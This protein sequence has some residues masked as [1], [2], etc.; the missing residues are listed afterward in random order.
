[1][2][3]RP[4]PQQSVAPLDPAK[5]GLMLSRGLRAARRNLQ[6]WKP[7]PGEPLVIELLPGEEALFK[8]LVRY[9]YSDEIDESTAG[10]DAELWRM[11]QL[12]NYYAVDACASTCAKLLDKT[13][14]S[15]E[16]SIDICKGALEQ[17]HCASLRDTANMLVGLESLHVQVE[18]TVFSLDPLFKS[19]PDYATILIDALAYKASPAAVHMKLKLDTE[20]WMP[21]KHYATAC[22]KSE[23]LHVQV[24][25]Q[26]LASIKEGT[27]I[28]LHMTKP[29][30]QIRLAGYTW[31][32][33]LQSEGAKRER[34]GL[35]ICYFEQHA[36]QPAQKR[37]PAYPPVAAAKL[38]ILKDLL[39]RSLPFKQGAWDP[40]GLGHPA[41]IEFAPQPA[42]G[43]ALSFVDRL[44]A[45]GYVKD[46][47]LR[48]SFQ[49]EMSLQQ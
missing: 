27:Q 2:T 47:Q 43:P 39:P 42:T 9:I 13:D 8:Q 37:I 10:N 22:V 31:E 21:R 41:A 1:M 18:N 20:V 49:V 5:S 12:A 33:L 19:L 45:K 40:L 25:V 24:P 14:L 7:A 26:E 6:A 15:L 34:L 38:T 32:L 23:E 16:L 44:R 28:D 35:F 3:S 46:E 36:Q 29:S 48:V 17:A 30:Q 4:A 11:L